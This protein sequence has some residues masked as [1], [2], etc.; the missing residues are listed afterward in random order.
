MQ[1]TAKQETKTADL[2]QLGETAVIHSLSTTELSVKLLQMGCLPGKQIT[3]VRSTLGGNPLYLRI[4]NQFFALRR[5]EA[6]QIAVH[7]DSS[8]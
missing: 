7:H 6:A 8:L 2:L 3:Y 4:D 5:E 1:N